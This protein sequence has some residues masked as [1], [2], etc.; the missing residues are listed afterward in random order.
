MPVEV[1]MSMVRV[2][3]TDINSHLV[4]E[5]DALIDGLL[6]AVADSITIKSNGILRRF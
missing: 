4:D 2:D 3:C 6:K 5:C 1:R